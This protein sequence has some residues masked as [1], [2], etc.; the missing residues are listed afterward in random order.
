MKIKYTSDGITI[1]L[2]KVYINNGEIIPYKNTKTSKRKNTKQT[3][4]RSTRNNR[5]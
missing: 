5:K 4:K 2:S 3:N 1:D